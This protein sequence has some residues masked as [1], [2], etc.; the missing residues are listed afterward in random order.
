MKIFFLSLLAIAFVCISA[1]PAPAPSVPY[2][3]VKDGMLEVNG[4]WS[5]TDHA[6]PSCGCNPGCLIN[7]KEDVFIIHAMTSACNPLTIDGNGDV[8]VFSGGSLS[9]SNSMSLIGSGTFTV[10]PGGLLNIQGDLNVSGNGDLEID[11][12]LMVTGDI[13]TTGSGAICG[14]GTITYGGSISGSGVCGS[15]TTTQSNALPIELSYFNVTSLGHKVEIEWTTATEI[16][17]DF[18]TI[19]R[20]TNGLNFEGIAEIEGAGSSNSAIDYTYVDETAPDGIIYYRL[21]Q[22]D[23]NGDTEAFDIKAVE[24]EGMNN[25]DECVLTVNPNPCPGNCQVVLSDCP[26]T[27]DAP[28][29]VHIMD[30]SGNLVNSRVQQANSDGSFRMS[31]DRDNNLKPGIYIVMGSAGNESTSTKV[32]VN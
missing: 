8:T 5:S 32:I 16:N 7:G 17:N 4:M 30:A 13:N 20:S 24:V 21:R 10:E 6:D 18:F 14:T 19:E 1:A 11:G 25:M 27:A 2:Y 26:G 22:T 9:L 28:V 23:F 15:V 29:L 3:S 31:I 12:D